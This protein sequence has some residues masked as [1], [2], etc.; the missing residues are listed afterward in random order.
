MSHIHDIID[1]DVRFVIDTASRK[2]TNDTGKRSLM[3]NDHNSE[4]F[5]FEMPRYVEGHDTLL[6]S[7]VEVHFNNISADKKAESRDVYIVDDIQVSPGVANR[8]IF[9]W[10]ISA[11]A[12][13][14]AGTLNFLIRFVC[15]DGE[16]ITY[17]WNTSIHS[18]I[19]IDSGMDNTETVIAEYSD[20]LAR[21]SE[22][23]EQLL[24]SDNDAPA[25]WR[26]ALEHGAEAINTALCAAGRNK[27]AFLFY[28][29]SHWN[30]GSQMSPAL[31]K[32]LYKHTGITKTFFGGDIV[33]DE[34]SDYDTMEY[35]WEWRRQL[36]DVPNHHSVAGNHDDGNATNNLFSEQYVYGYLLAAEETPDMV[37][38]DG[39]YYYIDNA[40]EKT[41]YICLDT[42]FQTSTAAQT[43]MRA[44]LTEALKSTQSGWHIVVV[45]HIWYLPD[46]DQ[47]DVRP[48]PLAGMS[49]EATAVCTVLDNYNARSGEFASGGAKVEFCIGGHVHRDYVGKTNGGI[50]IILVET[51]SHHCR[52]E[53]TATAG[54]KTEAAVNGIIADYNTNKV[55]VVRV[56]RGLSFIVDLTTGDSEN[57]DPPAEPDEPDTPDTPA[58]YTNVLD[59]AGYKKGVYLSNGIEG[60][61]ADAY[62][63]GYIPIVAAPRDTIYL[64]NVNMSAELSHGNRIACYKSD[65][66][67]IDGSTYGVT[68]DN[69][70]NVVRDSDGNIVSFQVPGHAGIAYIRLSAWNI[71]ETSIITINEPID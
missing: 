23:I 4:R 28:S 71:D 65:K 2:I 57:I 41:R 35:L 17:A 24:R 33:N 55:N 63:T 6:C 52:G 69:G 3:Q 45:S 15:L 46:Y 50:P 38:G 26:T 10:L 64:K 47:Y 48:I 13:K 54:T 19:V 67:Y 56:G 44:F 27:S 7:R 14:Y 51:D 42:G 66:T 20:V 60:T 12:T 53:F 1:A 18:G 32:Y 59:T 40:A 70:L 68:N 22:Q 5:S 21:W 36:K 8:V 62:T 58:T 30:Y 31:L 34:A 29:D 43:A 9:S 16:T 11:N 25:Y 49:T 61:D 39:L 37:M